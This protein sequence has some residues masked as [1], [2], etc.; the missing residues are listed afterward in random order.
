VRRRGFALV[1]ALL[2]VSLLLIFGLAF[3]GKRSWQ[4][5]ASVNNAL[6]TQAQAL[7]EAGMEDVRSKLEK[8]YDFPPGRNKPFSAAVYSYCEDLSFGASP[9]GSYT[10]TVDLGRRLGP[11]HVIRVASVGFAGPDRMNPQATFRIYAELDI[12]P[13]D[14]NSAGNPNPTYFRWINWK[15]EDVRSPPGGAQ[16]LP[17]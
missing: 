10:V 12:C 16:N 14:R 6:R 2:L 17:Q 5:R 11:F 8:D 13:E 3:L 15:E 1:L 9:V 4:Y 7:A